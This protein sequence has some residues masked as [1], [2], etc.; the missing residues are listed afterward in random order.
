MNAIQRYNDINIISRI[1]IIDTD[2]IGKG[3]ATIVITNAV[4][5]KKVKS[6]TRN[7][8]MHEIKRKLNLRL[9]QI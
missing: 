7:R 2:S 1:Y 8:A 3:K 4:G 6:C 9:F 5:Q